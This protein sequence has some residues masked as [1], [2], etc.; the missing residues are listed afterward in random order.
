MAVSVYVFS[1]EGRH[2]RTLNALTNAII[3]EFG[4]DS[5]GRLISVTDGDNNV[6]TIQRDANGN[7]TAIQSPF[8]QDTTLTLDAN[9]YLASITNP[10]GETT[11]F[12]YTADG[13]LT[14]VKQPAHTQPTQFSYDADGRLQTRADPAGGS[15]TLVRT[16]LGN[17]YEVVNTT[18]EGTQT[19]YR[20]EFLPDGQQQ[21]TT[22]LPDGTQAD[23]VI[24]TDG[25]QLTMQPD[26]TL[27]NVTQGP[28]PRFGM[29][30]PI[31]QDLTVTTPDG[32]M[33]ALSSSRTASLADPTNP[34]SLTTQT[35]SF[36]L[37]GRSFS[38][39]YAAAL[40][41]F[42]DTTPDGR[43]RTTKVDAQGRVTQQQIRNLTPTQFTYD[44]Q[45][46][47]GVLT[48]G[49]RSS[50]MSYNTNGNLASITDPA[51]RTNS[52]E[53]DEAG[54]VIKQILP[55]LREIHFT[56]DANG[57]V[58]SITPPGR[59][60]HQFTYTA[61]DLEQTYDPPDVVGV[62]PDV[63]Q[64]T[65]ND[66]RQVETIIRPDGQQILFSY[67]ATGRLQTQA[68]SHGSIGITYEPTTGN[69][70]M[71]TAPDGGTLSLA[72]DGTLVTDT[73]WAGT[74]AGSVSQSYDADLRV[75]TQ[76][77]NGANTVTF[78]YDSDSQLTGVGALTLS[79]DAQN[80][81]VTGSTLGTVTDTIGYNGFGE[82]M[83]Y[84]ASV[85]GSS[86][87]DLQYQ[88]DNLGRITQKTETI[89]GITTTFDYLYDAAGRLEEV[90]ENGTSLVTYTYD[91]N[92]NRTQAGTL[93]ATYDDQDRLLTYGTAAYTYTANGELQTRTDG[94]LTTTYNYDV[95]G[96]LLSVTLPDGTQ[97]DYIIDGENRRIGKQVNGT[98][99]QGFLYEDQLNPVA[100]LDGSGTIVAR[101]VYGSKTNVPDYLVKGG[102]TY[103][104]ISDHLGSPRLIVK[105]TD[106]TIAQ[107]MDYDAFGNVTLD[108]NPG[109]QPFGFAGGLYDRE[110]ELS[111]FGIRDYDTEAGR[112]TTKDPIH[113]DAGDTNIYGYVTNDPINIVDPNGRYGITLGSIN[114]GFLLGSII[115]ASGAIGGFA[116]EF[117]RR[118]TNGCPQEAWPLFVA[119][120]GGAALSVAYF[121]A[122]SGLPATWSVLE[123]LLFAFDAGAVVGVGLGTLEIAAG[124]ACWGR[125]LPPG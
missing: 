21:R 65:Y 7:P 82:S 50:L 12:T 102:L 75:A 67:D 53:Y 90:L 119:S 111:R 27:I 91:N 30:A 106:G 33:A 41:T 81:L 23:T 122:G 70:S 105:T 116:I 38:S 16:N 45:G 121:Y 29:Q 59:S 17:G 62:V 39:A 42:I 84:T 74:V 68:L 96:N 85:S 32:Q 46:R 6:T 115:G 125:A 78:Q 5:A 57:N 10:A 76:S 89:D 43:Q 58:T 15:D 14:G 101:F 71:V 77:V 61:V 25:S 69:K 56:Y 112:W 93:S 79:R 18:A 9:G 3:H 37:N 28:D 98:L 100:E 52:F 99:V 83:S 1:A 49:A 87:F 4:Y 2:L 123:T 31:G 19:T 34:L 54:R 63:T 107:R 97:I 35:D 88:R 94:G 64:M 72:Y 73:T 117:Y 120:A 108:T 114:S 66:D 51:S 92:S 47:L 40:G 36:S 118:F 124:Y 44:A 20:V 80:G 60:A 95:L 22:V 109:F 104:I 113:F 103:R 24:G 8:G 13:L 110:T 55:D 11:T 86:V 48:Q 26:G